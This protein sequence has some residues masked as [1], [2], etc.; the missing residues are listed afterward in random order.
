MED[1]KKLYPLSFSP[2]EDSWS[3]GDETFV[4][5]DLGYRDSVASKGWLGG[6]TLSELMDMYMDRIV[7]ESVFDS[8]GRQFPV[9]VKRLAVKGRMPLLVCPDD[10]VAADRY[11]FLGKVKLWY[12][13]DAKPQSRIYLGWKHA[14]TAAQVYEGCAVSGIEEHLNAI[15]PKRGDVFVIEPG[16]VHSAAGDL[17]I[18]EVSE[19]SPMDFCLSGFGQPVDPE[20]FDENL[21]V[22]EALDFINYEPYRAAEKPQK[23]DEFSERLFDARQFSTSLIPLKNT[24]QLSGEQFDSFVIYTCIAGEASIKADG[25]LYRLPAG[26]TMLIPADVTEYMLA[27]VMD[28]TVLLETTMEKHNELDSYIDPSVPATLEGEEGEESPI[29]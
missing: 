6:N 11:D 10:E 21:N 19:S 26:Q 27:P 18:L 13:L 2:L 28:G 25:E 24:L 23:R 15:T 22:V 7:G 14:M 16:V 29:L 8:T 20:Q 3:W 1:S 5:A 4:L 12:V 17:T 9:E